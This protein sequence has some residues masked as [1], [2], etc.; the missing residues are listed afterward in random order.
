MT[1]TATPTPTTP[2]NMPNIVSDTV[3]SEIVEITPAIAEAMLEFNTRNRNLKKGSVIQYARDMRN[4]NWK[5]AGDPIRFDTTGRLLDG[6]TRLSAII[7]AGRPIQMTVL[8]GL[9]PETQMVMDSG[10]KR[11]AGDQLRMAGV[12]NVNKV[13]SASRLALLVENESV[14]SNSYNPT[15]TEIM[16]WFEDHDDIGEYDRPAT[17]VRSV[18]GGSPSAYMFAMWK[19]NQIDPATSALFWDGIYTGANLAT[20][21]PRLAFRSYM[22]RAAQRAKNRTGTAVGTPQMLFAIA[23]AWN[24]FRAGEKLSVIR[25]SSKSDLNAPKFN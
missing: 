18:L 2:L 6:Q 11:T 10:V 19:T 4:G 12:V 16:E 14:R 20:D 22:S 17:A 5:F 1:D 13:A 8:T 21:D 23:R 24:V 9:E 7:K 25:I 3:H 15:T